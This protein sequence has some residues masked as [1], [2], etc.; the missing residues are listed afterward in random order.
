VP[1]PARGPERSVAEVVASAT[2]ERANLLLQLLFNMIIFEDGRGGLGI[3]SY[4]E[5]VIRGAFLLVVLRQVR[6]S[7]RAAPGP[8]PDPG[9]PHLSHDIWRSSLNIPEQTCPLWLPFRPTSTK[10][11]FRWC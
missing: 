9:P 6:L 5:S 7:R 10:F 3:S 2:A 11:H 8:Q 1:L 4:C